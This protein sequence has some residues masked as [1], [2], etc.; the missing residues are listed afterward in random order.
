MKIAVISDI[1]GNLSALER[2]VESLKDEAVDKIVFLGDLIM[3]GPRPKEVFELMSDLNPDIWIKG[4]SDDWLSEL[5]DFEP[6]SDL[7]IMLKDMGLW[8]RDRIN[9]SIE[10]E[11]L[12]KPV[13]T[14]KEY[15]LQLFNF[16]HGTPYSHSHAILQDSKSAFLESELSN[17]KADKIV[18]GH[19]HLRFSMTFKDK[20]IKNFGAVS[21]PG[22]D[23]SLMARYGIIHIADTVFF[24]DRECEYDFSAYIDDLKNLNY[25]GN[26]LIFPKYGLQV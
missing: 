13:S 23:F 26:S 16:C 12:S 2:I 20:L 5:S 9:S 17:I 19:T 1:H 15:A 21:M 7:E 11:L 14:E 25:P 6:V 22:K 4:N 3:T 24:E 10:K 18:C 8:A